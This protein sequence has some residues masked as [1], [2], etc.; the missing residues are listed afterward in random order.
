MAY[1]QVITPST[2]WTCGEEKAFLRNEMA[3]PRQVRSL[4]SSLPVWGIW[5]CAKS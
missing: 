1:R 5:M 4:C 3:L 2:P